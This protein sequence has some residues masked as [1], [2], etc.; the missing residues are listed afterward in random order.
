MIGL[1]V[2]LAL[3]LVWELVSRTGLVPPNL[4]PPPSAV[5]VA[6]TDLAR[7]GELLGHVEVTLFRVCAGF[8]AGTV[9]ATL[10]GALTGTSELA[11]RLFDPLLQGLRSIPS[12]AWVPLFILWLGIFEASK[13]TLIAVGAFFP[14][15]LN[16]MTGIRQVDRK[17]VEVGH[18]YGYRGLALI[19]R[20]LLPATL[21]AYV[22]GLRGGLGLGWMFVVAAEVMGASEGLGFLL[23]DGQMTGRPAIIL[24]SIVL[25]AILGK[26]SDLALATIGQRLLAWQDV[27]RTNVADQRRLQAV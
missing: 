15:Y 17:L 1:V 21:P 2:P 8:L 27:M 25:F 10:L 22:T 18:A 13:V 20:V 7:S 19:R 14:V 4:L 5:V 24:G 26:A 12:I 9:A 16:L 3:A 6:M 11:R 23:V